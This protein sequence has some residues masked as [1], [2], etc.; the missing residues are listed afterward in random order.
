[1]F[2]LGL[3]DGVFPSVNNNEGFLND[4][5]R[6]ILKKKNVELA[7][8][9]LEALYND[10]FNIYKAFTT[11]EEK[12]Y[13][14]YISSDSEGASQKPSTLL[15]KIKKIFP[16]LKEESDIIKRPQ[17]IANKKATFDE[18][19]LNIRNYKDGKEIDDVWFEIYKIF[20]QDEEWKE[21]LE[22]S[23]RALDF[24]N[25][26]DKINKEN[27]QKLY[28]NTLKTSVSRLEK[29]KSCPFSFY[30]KYGLKIEEKDSYKMESL[31]TGS[32]MHD[33]IDTF[34]E[35]VQDLG[36]SVRE[37][38]EEKLKE[39][40]DEIIEEKL[41]LPKNYIFISSAKFK[42]QT[43][44]LKR[45]ILKAIKYIIRTIKESE[46]DIF[47]HELEF[48]ENK[49]YPPITV[50]LEDGKKVQIIGKIDR[51]DIAQDENRKILKDYRLQIFSKGNRFK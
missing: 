11:S 18:L 7:M 41:N 39:I 15:L 14:S 44:K 43:I 8:T 24:S 30:L 38:Q 48:G 16:N 32:F 33:V 2:I 12:L 21:K 50:K 27:I 26:P 23:I 36:F 13:L 1:M 34:F 28:G 19:L 29:Y 51:V 3:N 4:N 40:I 35:R 6:E 37:M 42:N 9:T 22:K 20:K 10:N 49:K 47:G 46:F 31:D 25:M 17:M 45:L 5:D